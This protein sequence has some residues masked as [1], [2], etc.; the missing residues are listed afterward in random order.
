MQEETSAEKGEGDNSGDSLPNLEHT[1]NATFAN[2]VRVHHGLGT[3]SNK[4]NI[5]LDTTIDAPTDNEAQRGMTQLTQH[6]LPLT[7]HRPSIN[8]SIPQAHVRT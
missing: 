3:Q 2:D 8:R 1:D 4:E 5:P 6:E 7:G